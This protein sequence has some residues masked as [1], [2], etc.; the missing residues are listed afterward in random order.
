MKKIERKET[1]RDHMDTV[2]LLHRPTCMRLSLCTFSSKLFRFG[3]KE[4]K[5]RYTVQSR[6]QGYC[7]IA[8]QTERAK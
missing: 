3:R 1:D 5:R 6:V 2:S 8:R 7:T 4:K